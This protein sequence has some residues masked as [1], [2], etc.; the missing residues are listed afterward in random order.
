[1]RIRQEREADYEAIRAVNENA[2]GRAVEAELV[3]AIRATDRFLPQLSLVAVVDDDVV[4]HVLLSYVEL[5][6][7]SRR[8]LQ[9]G[10]LAV[11][12]SQQQRGIGSA[13][14]LEALRTAEARDE[15]LVMLEGDPN[16]YGRFGFRGSEQLG[17][18]APPGVSARHF[19]VC[20][21]IAYDPSVRGQAVYSEP[22]RAIS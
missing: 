22:F 12:R 14:V 4:G 6:P 17:I 13:L 1:M 3:E 5:E 15:P 9:L 19:L 20:T 7:G 11:R 8:V 18:S 16:Y 2:F 21:L 10:P